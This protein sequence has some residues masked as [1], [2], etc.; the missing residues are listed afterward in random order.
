VTIP[1]PDDDDEDGLGCVIIALLQK[2]RRKMRSEGKKDAT[3]GYCLYKLEEPCPGTLNHRFFAN[4]KMADRSPAFINT[5]EVADYHKLPPGEYV[6]IPS[7]FE[8]NEEADF[9]LRVYSEKPDDLVEMDEE[10]GIAEADPDEEFPDETDDDLEKEEVG[11]QAFRDLAGEDGEID[12]YELKDLLNDNFMQEF[13]FD[14]FSADMCRSMVSMKDADLS[15]KLDF[16]DFQS[17]WKDLMMCKRVFVSMDTD[18]NGYFNSYEFR[19]VLNTLGLRVSNAT[20]NAIVMRYSDKEGHVRFDDFV[21]CTIKLKTL[22]RTF[23]QK[24][25]DGE[26]TVNFQMDEFLQQ[27][28][29]A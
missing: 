10:T 12:C 29:Y 22:F 16:D 14:G 3:I 7:T 11:L 13:E 8:P 17:L 24:D 5:R 18:G 27:C 4:N 2:H 21:A 1:E 15:G 26:G 9:L 20:F 19:R 6:I 25:H 23:K 28:M